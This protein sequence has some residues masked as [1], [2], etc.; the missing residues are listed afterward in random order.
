MASVLAEISYP[1]I[2]IFDVGPLRLSLHGL[3]AGVGFVV[4][5]WLMIREARRRG[6]AE[7][8]ITSV[9][10]WALVGSLVE[11]LSWRVEPEA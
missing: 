1:P 7:D 10:T 11:L 6:F 9:L 2:P 5:S 4:G 3:M 8:K